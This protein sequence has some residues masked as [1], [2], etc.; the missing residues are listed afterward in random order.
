MHRNK[1]AK[2]KEVDIEETK[3]RMWLLRQEETEAQI[4]KQRRYNRFQS[5]QSR[6]KPD[7]K[8]HRHGQGHC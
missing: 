6:S 2:E 7:K 1:S 4:N 3:K 5:N 8:P